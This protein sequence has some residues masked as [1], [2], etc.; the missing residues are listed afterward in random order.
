MTGDDTEY[1]CEDPGTSCDCDSVHEG[2]S[3]E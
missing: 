2:D 3:D 1:L